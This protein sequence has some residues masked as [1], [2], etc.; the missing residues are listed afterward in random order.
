M[1]R[2]IEAIGPLLRPWMPEKPEPQ[3][4]A[5]RATVLH[6]E[7]PRPGFG[8]LD[9][10][11]PELLAEILLRLPYWDLLRAACVSKL[12]RDL[13]QAEPALQVRMFKKPSDVYVDPGI[14]TPPADDGSESLVLHPLL[15]IA[16]YAIG[17]PLSKMYIYNKGGWAPTFGPSNDLASIPAVFTLS[18]QLESY[19][20]IDHF[21]VD[22]QN[23]RGVTVLDVFS[24]LQNAA[25]KVVETV[26]G[27]TTLQDAID[28]HI[29]Y[30]GFCLPKRIGR[31]LTV[32]IT[33]GS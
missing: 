11:P 24:G 16:E 5:H 2:T 17:D 4:Q 6:A 29:F 25:K 8:V 7:A 9:D 1:N 12:W 23:P 33:L 26:D 32:R 10:F 20:R 31:G 19:D 22:V 13:L 21:S 30:E 28:P 18:M 14:E 27:P 3:P 15:D